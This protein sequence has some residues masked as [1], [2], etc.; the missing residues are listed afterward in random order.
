MTKTVTSNSLLEN[1][2]P[3][4]FCVSARLASRGTYGFYSGLS[5]QGCFNSKQP[6]KIKHLLLEQRV[7]LLTTLEDGDNVS[8]WSKGQASFLPI[9]LLLF[10]YLS[11]PL[12]C[13]LLEPRFCLMHLGILNAYL[14]ALNETGPW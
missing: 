7:S 6:W 5:F 9:L 11:L 2:S 12:D 4:V 8:L 10:P 13:E 1:K 3:W 14:R